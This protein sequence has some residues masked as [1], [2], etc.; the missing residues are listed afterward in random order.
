MKDYPKTQEFTIFNVLINY[1][2]KTLTRDT[3]DV[4]RKQIGHE[5]TE[6][7][8]SWAFK[9]DCEE[10]QLLREFIG[11]TIYDRS[12]EAAKEYKKNMFDKEND[13]G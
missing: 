9:P 5:I 2:G 7:P 4:I 11:S 8:C 1:C 13:N 12:L 3:L 6:G 10:R